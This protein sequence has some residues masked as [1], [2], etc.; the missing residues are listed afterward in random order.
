M[1][2]KPNRAALV[3]NGAR[4]GLSNP[5]GRVRREFEAAL[6]VEFVGGLHE[7]NVAFLDEIEEGET[8]PDV[9]L[10]NRNDKPQVRA[11]QMGAGKLAI[12]LVRVEHGSLLCRQ[13]RLLQE[14]FREFA[15]LHAL[16]EPDLLL[17]RQEIG[18]ADL[19]QIEPNRITN[20][21]CQVFWVCRS[22]SGTIRYRPA[23]TGHGF[24]GGLVE[25]FDPFSDQ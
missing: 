5:P 8:A 21:R 2:W 12:K 22:V 7:T 1:N 6:V 23:G 15:A 19:L 4:N 14:L 11:D 18:V 17:H 13:A 24:Q 9:F 25:D 3:G 10:C 20:P 16:G